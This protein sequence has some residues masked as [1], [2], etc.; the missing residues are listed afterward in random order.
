MEKSKI[1]T[2]QNG[3]IVLTEEEFQEIVEVFKTLAEW[4]KDLKQSKE[5]QEKKPFPEEV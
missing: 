1:R 4:D 3:E 5:K 2:Y